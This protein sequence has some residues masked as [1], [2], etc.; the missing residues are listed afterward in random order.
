MLRRAHRLFCA[1]SLASPDD[2]DTHATGLIIA[3]ISFIRSPTPPP[4]ITITTATLT[5]GCALRNNFIRSHES[6]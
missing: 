3:D 2:E 1:Y 4:I 6:S 5:D